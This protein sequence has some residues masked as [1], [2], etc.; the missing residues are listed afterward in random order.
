M[1]IRILHIFM[2]HILLLMLP[3]FLY[4][5][6]SISSIIY[7]LQPNGTTVP[8][9]IYGDEFFSYKKDMAGR[10]V[11]VGP[12]GFL[13]D[14]GVTS[15]PQ[16][17]LE[18]ARKQNRER[19]RGNRAMVKA[20]SSTPFMDLL[21]AYPS[22]IKVPVLLVEFS[23]V[24]F[25]VS[26]PV[27]TFRAQLNQ[28]GYLTGGATGSAADYFGA[29]FNGKCSFLFD[30]ANHVIT[31]SKEK[32]YYGEDGT[33]SIDIN[34]EQ[35][36]T[37][38]CNAA[39]ATGV[40]FSQYDWFGEGTVRDVAIIFAGTSQSE[41]AKTADLWPQYHTLKNVTYQGKSILAFTTSS[42]LAGNE[43]QQQLSGIGTFCHEFCHA[44][45]LPDM[46]DTNG[47][48]EGL[49]AALWESLSIMDSGNYLNNG[50]TPPYF[51]AIEKE[52]LGY[53]PIV[54]K[55]GTSYSMLPASRAGSIYR[56]DTQNSGEYFLL[57]GRELQGWDLFIGGKGMVVYRVDKSASVYGGIQSALRWDYNNINCLASHQC[58]TVFPASA[59]QPPLSEDLFFPGISNVTEL[60]A[61]GNVKFV[62]WSGKPL[63]VNISGISYRNGV[64]DF[65]AVDGQAYD[66][67][68]PYAKVGSVIPYQH[69]CRISWLNAIDA[70]IPE[71][72]TWKISWW[73]SSNQAPSTKQE[74]RTS[75]TYCYLPGLIPATTYVVSITFENGNLYG[76]EITT[77]FST[78]AITSRMPYMAIGE[79]YQV[80]D[81]FDFRV[82]NLL[83][84]PLEIKRYVNSTECPDAFYKFGTSGDYVIETIIKYKDGS[85]EH[86]KKRL[87]V[88]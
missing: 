60:S 9:R 69:D 7:F 37:D 86:I 11:E 20:G 78:R 22:V 65:K 15:V 18:Q 52:I 24:K 36:F 12:D 5:V 79:S 85:S 32:K 62:D 51:T 17:I 63:S 29:N 23:D 77:S 87:R 66:P 73:V 14:T 74:L 27:S 40:D 58:A 43:K 41:S 34:I 80:G 10:I 75:R 8:I 31:L 88:H 1:K 56:I 44:L 72:G 68:Q 25:S 16:M 53:E 48:N 45:G 4:A 28:S 55:P 70:D 21:P 61:C 38:V 59:A 46:Y 30:V 47:A 82:Q 71:S 6:K 84:E 33:E 76:K 26:N 50:N 35:L 19:I 67:S 2:I 83:E 81:V 42:E 39:V 57:E 3:E 13:H 64:L 54:P 49:G